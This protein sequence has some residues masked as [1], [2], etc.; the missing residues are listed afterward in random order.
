M[1]VLPMRVAVLSAMLAGCMLAGCGSAVAVAG[2]DELRAT[3]RVV[4]AYGDADYDGGRGDCAFGDDALRL[5]V[6]ERGRRVATLPFCSSYASAHAV[7]LR[8]RKS[9]RYL[10]LESQSGR[11][12]HV[13]KRYLTLYRLGAE[14]IELLRT[15]LAWPIGPDQYFGYRYTAEPDGAGGLRIRLHGSVE[16]AADATEPLDAVGER[17]RTIRV[18]AGS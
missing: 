8:D 16:R 10:L 5:S 1:S 13:A 4:A 7:L 14:P 12:T 3:I 2:A 9:R 6:R 15:P 17:E 11:G 18:E